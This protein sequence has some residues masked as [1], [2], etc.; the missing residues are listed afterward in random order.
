MRYSE[1]NKFNQ[2]LTNIYIEGSF[3][4]EYSYGQEWSAVPFP[5]VNKVGIET[6]DTFTRGKNKIEKAYSEVV[7]IRFGDI[8][9]TNTM[10]IY[11]K[12]IPA[13][14]TWLDI[15]RSLDQLVG[16]SGDTHH[17]FPEEL[18]VEDDTLFVILGS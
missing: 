15:F 13:N 14:A 9:L 10:E 18:R 16:D 7:T 11:L 4:D 8:D 2:T 17:R 3:N 1:I 5:G 12:Q 6:Y